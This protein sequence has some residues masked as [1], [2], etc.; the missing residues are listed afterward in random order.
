MGMKA[1]N[2]YIPDANFKAKLLSSSAN[3]TVAKDLNGNYFA[4]DANGDGQIQQSE[5]N[6]VSELN[7]LFNGNAGIPY[8]TITSIHGIKNFTALKT[9]KLETGNTNYYTGSIDLSNM[10]N[11]ENIDLSIDFKGNLNHDI[12]VS[13]CTALQIFKTGLISASPN[14]T[15]TG[16]TGLKD[17]KLIGYNDVYGTPTVSIGT[18]NLNNFISLKS[19]YI[20]N[21]NLNTLLLQGCNALDNITLKEYSTNTISNTL[22][23]SNLQNLK[24]LTLNKYNVNLDAHNCPNLIS[25]IGGNITDL[26]VQDCTNLIDLKVTSFINTINVIN[27]INLKNIRGIPK[28]NSIDLSTSNLQNLDSVV[29]YHSDCYQQSTMLSSLNVQNCP[30]LRQITT[31]ELNLTTLDVSNLP[32]L[33]SLQI[34]H[35]LYDWQ[36]QNLTHINASNCPLLNVFDIKGTYQLQS[37]NLQN[38]SSLSNI[39]LHNGNSYENRYSIN[40]INLTGCTNF[41]NLDIRKCSFTALSLPNLPNLKTINCSDN[42]LT[43]LDF[44]NLQALET[45]TCGKNN[46]TTLVVHDLPNLINFDYSD[47]QLA[48]VDFQN[49]PKLKNLSFNNNQLTNLILANIPLIE[50]LEC[51]NNLLINLNL[52]NLPLKYLDCSNNQ[53]SSLA[54]N[55][56]T[57]LEFLNCAHNQISSLNL[58][59]NNNLG[60]LD[61]SYN[62]LTSLDA[63]ML[64]D[65]LS[66]Y[67]VGL[68]DCSHN[69]LQTLNIAGVHSMNEINFSYNNLTNINLD[70]IS[71]LLGIKGSNNQLTSVDLSK[72]YHDGYTTYTELLDL[73]NNNLTTLIL[74]NNITEV[75]PYTDLSGNPNLHYICCDD[76]EINDLQALISQYGYNC[77]I[78]TYC[79]FTPGGNYN[80]ITG[81]VKFDETNNGCDTNDEA[82]QHLKL[83]VNNGTTTEETFVKNDG[84]YDFF[85][86]AGDFTVTAEPENPSLYTVTPSTFTTNFAD[87]NN[88]ISTQNICVTKNGNVKDLEVVFAPVTDA[89]PGFDAV[90]KVIWRNKGNTTLSGSVSIN[91]NNSK[92][93]FLSS[94][95]P[96]SI[97]GNQVTFNFTNLKP[98]ANTASEITFNIN[99]PT[100]ATN[101]VHIG[102]IL[103]FSA[104][105]TPLSGDANQDDNQFTYNQTVVGSYDPND[106][107][108]LEGNT[109]P[110]SMVGKY[111]HYMVN[112]ENTGT[113]PASNIVVEM[114][115]NPDDFDISSLQLQN[116]SHQSYT[117]ING[118]K[119]EF[120][121][122]D[123][124]LAAAAHGNIALKIKSKNNLASG[125]SVSNKANIYFD[126]NFPIETNDAV[127]NIDG[128]TLSSKDITKDKTSV[129]IYPNPTKGD[130][131]ITADSKINSI[132]IYDAQGRIVQKQI[133]I[134]SQHTKLSI[135][136]A[137]SGV[138][139]FKII[140]EKEVLMKK[141]I[142]N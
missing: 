98:Y 6:Q 4:I 10:T 14:F 119:V 132:E 59:N 114:E 101:P 24:T 28:C 74:K 103:N 22:N 111:L 12:N 47:G 17:V 7:I 113:A 100:H 118:N 37:I 2:I 88:N 15:F 124:N 13:N 55:N 45:I 46:L 141:I 38:N 21:I 102:D 92:M 64:K 65:I 43:N 48:S 3:N 36:G 94:V 106:I 73:S 89:R 1:Q 29:F 134:N 140:T 107:T 57:L 25:I 50:K 51:N 105:I 126:Y 63:S 115:I 11:L 62:Q 5:A 56:L 109:I 112:F 116:T 131:N 91:F 99:P 53:I 60:Y 130:V 40:N 52:Q 127:T 58:T 133:G 20:E 54:V 8:T 32:K 138:Y 68:M 82:F 71:A 26:N 31:Y 35:C 139:I 93:S 95:L 136:S 86:Q 41:T 81:T 135:H 69:Q 122:K 44:L 90:Y 96:S 75:T 125:D 42:F 19:L 33:E 104:N 39:I 121:M 78:N 23:V 120:M 137:I 77:N 108:C 34:L 87:S 67:P 18:I 16:C 142:K 30:K 76:V 97:S 85:T 110:L 117:K 129:N 80:T 61:C 27:C 79:N 49:L 70:N 83:K 123:I 128:A 9:F 84:K 66:A 72:Y